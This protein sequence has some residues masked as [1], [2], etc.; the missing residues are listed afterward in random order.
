MKYVHNYD[1]RHLKAGQ[2]Y[3]NVP[4]FSQICSTRIMA[5]NSSSDFQRKEEI[6]T[7]PLLLQKGSRVINVTTFVNK[8]SLI[9]HQNAKHSGMTYACGTCGKIFEYIGH[10]T[11]HKKICNLGP[12]QFDCNICGKRCATEGG[13]RRHQEN[14]QGP[15]K[16]TTKKA[17]KRKIEDPAPVSSTK[18][19]TPFP[20][21]RKYFRCRKCVEVF[22]NRHNLWVH[23]MHQHYQV[24][25]SL[26]PMPWGPNL[27]PWE[28]ENGTVDEALREVYE[29]AEPIILEE[30]RPEPVVSTYN[31]PIDNGISIQQ[32]MQFTE[33]IYRREQ[34]AFHLNLVFGIILQNRETL[35][36]RY[37][38]PYNN[39]TVLDTPIY[40]SR[41]EDLRKLFLR[42]SRMDI[43]T[44]LLRN[45]PDTKWIPVLLTNV[46]FTIYS[47]HYPLGIG[48]VPD[49]LRNHHG[50]VPL[51][52]NKHTGQ[53][54]DD[55]LCALRC[56]A[57]HRG[58][59]VKSVEGAAH[60]YYK[61]WSNDD[62]TFFQGISFYEFPKFEE[63]F[64]ST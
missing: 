47:T 52:V 24:G 57:V 55:S 61:Q 56:L 5:N 17:P 59:D 43:T 27:A 58:Y 38:Q 64:K 3:L 48:I 6:Q 20:K 11:R 22:E 44:H 49:Y 60:E 8:K 29:T 4:L 50:I 37:F 39:Y 19:S 46:V 30:H 15:S 35:S 36:Y 9:R 7:V 2:E 42:L 1:K 34:H 31:F 16:S 32:L 13:L 51:E 40:I 23:G 53:K 54:Y 26:Q 12:K 45:R 14:H 28:N 25:G 63:L 41:R 62:I 10:R 18:R 21:P 33:D